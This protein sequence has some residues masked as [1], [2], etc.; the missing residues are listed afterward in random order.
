MS[1][2]INLDI[3]CLISTFTMFNIYNSIFPSLFSFR[4]H[5]YF[6]NLPLNV[7]MKKQNRMEYLIFF[8]TQR[9]VNIFKEQG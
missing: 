1:K 7:N 3:Y 6:P 5:M 9:S 2:F 8:I 4:K